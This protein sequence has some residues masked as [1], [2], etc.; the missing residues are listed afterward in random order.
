MRG[1]RDARSSMSCGICAS[2]VGGSPRGLDREWQIALA[3]VDA[4]FARKRVRQA[5][6]TLRLA[7]LV[8]RVFRP[9]AVYVRV[10]PSFLSFLRITSLLAA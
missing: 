8:D 6:R 3:T 7:N 2:L 4:G 10:V 1:G 9:P 5:L